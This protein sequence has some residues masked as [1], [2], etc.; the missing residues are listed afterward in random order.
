MNDPTSIPPAFTDPQSQNGTVCHVP[1]STGA[2][3]GL[4]RRYFYNLR[5][6][7]DA[8][9]RLIRSNIDGYTLNL[10]IAEGIMSIGGIMDIKWA[11]ERRV[12]CGSY[13]SVQGA[14]QF[15]GETSV[16]MFTMAVAAHSFYR[17]VLWGSYTICAWTFVLLFAIINWATKG[18]DEEPFFAPTGHWCWINHKY[19]WE[20]VLGEYMWMWMA[21]VGN[22][23]VYIPLFFVLRGHFPN[24]GTEPTAGKVVCG[25]ES[26]WQLWNPIC[27]TIIVLPPTITLAWR[28]I[29]NSTPQ[30][31]SYTTASLIAHA[32]FR[33]SGLVNVLL[34]MNTRVGLLLIRSDGVLYENDPRRKREDGGTCIDGAHRLETLSTEG[35][36]RQQLVYHR[37]STSSGSSQRQNKGPD[38]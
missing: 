8:P 4:A 24:R 30:S 15:I 6:P 37:V 28:L 21:G 26:W 9:W 12:T 2:V 13:C 36:P 16:A 23:V 11:S 18:T 34:I 35:T 19:F 33:L 27:Y 31:P 20:G 3:L 22:I 10:L 29:N 38:A 25:R 14:L 5:H 7:P 17:F 1:L 32:L